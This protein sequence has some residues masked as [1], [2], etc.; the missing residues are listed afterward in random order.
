MRKA[1]RI[2]DE[3]VKGCDCGK[4]GDTGTPGMW[5]AVRGRAL[6]GLWHF[7]AIEQVL[8]VREMA[9]AVDSGLVGILL[10]APD[11]EEDFPTTKVHCADY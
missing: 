8:A 6:I 7:R 10:L 9:P 11:Q 5:G 4:D 2:Q 3:R 1:L